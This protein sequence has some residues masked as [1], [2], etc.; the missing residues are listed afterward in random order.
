MLRRPSARRKVGSEQIGLNL[1]P[2]MDTFVTLIAF[3]M[4]TMVFVVMTHVETPLPTASPTEVANKLKEKPIR[5]SLRW[6]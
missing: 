4:Y 2:M 3:L 5:S 1:V 6:T